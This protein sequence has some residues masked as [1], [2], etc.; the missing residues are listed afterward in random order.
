[1][2][3]NVLIYLNNWFP[4]AKNHGEYTVTQ[5]SIELPFLKAGQYFR[6]VGSVFNDGLH[7]YPVTDLTD[8]TFNGVIWALA[9]PKAVQ[10]LA[11]EVT[12][13]TAKNQPSAYTSE[14]FGGYSY[15]KAA[16]ADGSPMSWEGVFA[17]RLAPW[18]K[19][20]GVNYEPIE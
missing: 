4:V 20:R 5:G 7:Q 17:S 8:E 6:I 12:E 11:T 18:R 15:S 10:S 9:V 2:L 3:E 1:M 19:L 16:N 13:W 14:S